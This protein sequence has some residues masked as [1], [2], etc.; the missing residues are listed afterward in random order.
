MNNEQLK[1]FLVCLP[2]D[3]GYNKPLVIRQN[4]YRV[5]YYSATNDGK[6]LEKLFPHITEEEL[7]SLQY[8]K[9]TVITENDKRPFYNIRTSRTDYSH[10]SD[11]ACA[12]PFKKG[13][14]VY[15]CE[16]CSYDD[17][18]VLCVHCFNKDD[19]ID[20]NV[21]MYISKGSSGGICDCGDPEAFV[22]PLH[23][24]CSQNIGVDNENDITEI[25]RSLEET[26]RVCLDYILD[27]T[28]FSVQTL[29]FIHANIDKDGSPLTTEVISNYSSLPAGSY[30]GAI[31]TNSKDLWY[32]I[33]WNDEHHDFPQAK[34]AI[35]AATGSDE[36][37]ADV[38]AHEIN[39]Y[40]NYIL[41]E[42]GSF[43][44]LL[45]YKSVVEMDGLVST[46][47][48]ARDYM[49]QIIVKH[50]FNW[51]IDI[52]N[53]SGNTKF[54][55][56]SKSYLVDL[57]LEPNFQFSKVFPAD[58]ITGLSINDK[59]RC[60][61]NGILYDG[62]M[63]NLG[64]CRVKKHSDI[65]EF[66]RP[67]HIV[68]DTRK[69]LDNLKNSRLQFL[70]TFQTRFSSAI[71][72]KLPNLLLPP[73]MA[74]NEKKA[75]FSEQFVSIY[76]LLI[77]TMALSDR[78]ENLNILD[79]ISTQVLTCPK[80]VSG[81]VERD[82]VGN[83]I[84]PVTQIIEE[85]SSRWNYDSGYPN[86]VEI[87][88]G[89][90]QTYR[91]IKK[92]VIR[93]IRDVSYLADKNLNEGSKFLEQ[94]NLLMLLLFLRNFQGYWP[95]ERK[96]GDHVEREILDFV[97]HLEYST[98]ILNITKLIAR[99]PIKDE[100][101]V[102]KVVSLI[103]EFLNLRKLKK[104]APGIAEFRV[105]K[106]PTSFVNPINSLLSYLLQFQR[107]EDYQEVL[108]NSNEPFMNISDVSL[109]SIVLASQIKIG[110]WIR[111]G[112]TVS[113]Q[114]S[115]YTTLMSDLAYYRD[116]HLN[117]VA[118]V[119]DDPR[120]TLYNFL[121]RWEL[122]TWFLNDVSHDKTIYQER[123]S[124]ICE[125]FVVF[126]YNL[127]TDR[128]NFKA[129]SPEERIIYNA[130]QS[131]C[132]TLC[133]EPKSYSELRN[134]VDLEVSELKD[135]D[136]ILYDCADYQ[137]PT[138][139]VDSGIYRLKAN[140]F[141]ELD[142]LNLH[143]DSSQFESVS[144]ALIKNVARSKGISED[145]VVLTPS[146]FKS[147]VEMV[148]ERIGNFTKTKDFAKLLYK[149]LQASLDDA[150]ET[151]LPQLLHLIH[152]VLKDDELKHGPDYLCE[153]FVSIPISDLLLTI[154]ESTMSKHIVKKADF[155]VDQFISKDKRIFDSLID[156]FG[157]DYIQSY[158]KRKVGLF[159]SESEKK[160]RLAEERKAKIMKKFAKKR[161]KFLE[162]NKDFQ[163]KEKI[164]TEQSSSRSCVLCGDIESTDEPFG[165]LAY[166]T[167]T[168]TLWKIPEDANDYS[169]LAFLSL[170]HQDN[171]KNGDVYGNG[172]N[173]SI[174]ESPLNNASIEACV[175]STC[176]HFMHF[177]CYQR[178]ANGLK[179]FPCP[180]CHSLHD[181]FIPSFMPPESDSM[182]YLSD[183]EPTT[184]KYNQILSSTNR[185]KS[186]QLMA[187]QV[188]TAYS[189]VNE[190]TS[191]RL[192]KPIVE[193]LMPYIS[194]K[195]YLVEVNE[196]DRSFNRLQ[197][198][199]VLIADVIRMNE[200]STRLDGESSLF[201]FLDDFPSAAK[202]LIK[203]LIQC[204]VSAYETR[205]KFLS[206]HNDFK[207]QTETFWQSDILLDGTFN[208]VVVLFFQTEESFITL[209]RLGYAKL[210]T[211]TIYSLL[212]RCS[213]DPG[214][215]YCI[216]QTKKVLSEA[217]YGNFAKLVDMFLDS[218]DF[219]SIASNKT[220]FLRALYYSVERVL[221]PY[222]RNLTIF[223]DMLTSLM[224]EESNYVSRG[225]FVELR[226]K[227][228]NQ[229]RVDSSDAL[230]SCLGL[231]PFQDLINGIASSGVDENFAFE[232]KVFEIVLNAK[233]PKHMHLGVLTL[234]YPGVIQLIN[235]PKDYTSCI[236][237]YDNNSIQGTYDYIICLHCGAKLKLSRQ[238]QHMSG[239]SKHTSIFYYPR[240]NV[241]KVSTHI[242][243]NQFT[244]ELFA[245]Y[246]TVH[247]EPKR[248][249]TPGK[250][251]L[252]QF[253]YKYL[254]KLWLNQG[255]YG[256]VTRSLFGARQQP[257]VQFD[258][259]N[260][261]AD[262][263][264]DD[265]DEDFDAEYI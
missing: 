253:R 154:V 196:N 11:K 9:D 158:K 91:S 186:Q 220:N 242:E 258:G 210:L 124:S 202:I 172:Y 205:S 204:R 254:N 140:I 57:L 120:A 118:A 24:K 4:L 103:T 156:C 49:R 20:H 132:Y 53:F 265:E 92:A 177:S 3:L 260:F 232:Y 94:D 1:R 107:L 199:S 135:F 115:L 38:I 188:N 108:K 225:E 149:L 21:Y 155:L 46:I 190:V 229:K 27:V 62:Q 223:K 56:M 152:A 146:L 176:G 117:Q 184:I 228:K 74:D 52:T 71:R 64:L 250:A 126:I 169:S 226:E 142:P 148:D 259:F 137:A 79:E 167:K 234:D 217:Q 256:F 5:L 145:D 246:L 42:A 43:R 96:Y 18:C 161:E 22:R 99:N 201:T 243:H 245:P 153:S 191:K 237:D 84:G 231:A 178:S 75:N 164:T 239:C 209:A 112:I 160:K 102:R 33:L 88:K 36:R 98:T 123:F 106:D 179:H 121:D 192:M 50:I 207:L 233:I 31:D 54:R 255:L 109:R 32:L 180:L 48:S 261:T 69:K 58:F 90:P 170:D 211:I 241:L 203:S 65:K 240:L 200:I 93:G 181:V 215:A 10:P 72:K 6:S 82:D 216:C 198:L 185:L 114:A 157:E 125:K 113:R 40:G 110:F 2:S 12:R 130:K 195:R 151:Y 8:V 150:D 236:T 61:E 166:K 59:R 143:L 168:S 60:F 34:R 127:L 105:S 131:I 35:R 45:K 78:E 80:C 171:P 264:D 86:F 175:L 73:I 67:A 133:D 17:T 30:G 263:E 29:P 147:G 244:I 37:K 197:N 44:E 68:L 173:Y 97:V 23:C 224:D 136:S 222:F 41:R 213:R 25:G 141:E 182:G 55:E 7:E 162:N 212:E 119:L 138:G 165:I 208:E 128:S 51:L 252:N 39:T 183:K 89:R 63:V 101:Q 83:L 206:N 47:C 66:M 219:K 247:G 15:R 218:I 187:S 129:L 174:I 251:T 76:P 81:I 249:R 139:L 221:L 77:T 248:P 16:Q 194:E 214:Y 70:L 26:I 122:L 189:S 28:N 144:E 227:I 111:N 159:E 262:D 13:E 134:H 85:H 104:Q 116:F 193:D 230:T 14:P 19:H 100:S 235:L 257:G 238:S 87:A 95:I 163:G